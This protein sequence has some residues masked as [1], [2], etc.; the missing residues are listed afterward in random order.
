MSEPSTTPENNNTAVDSPSDSPTAVA[1]P[2]KPPAKVTRVEVVRPPAHAEGSSEDE[3]EGE[4]GE[5]AIEDSQILE[6]LPDETEDI[7][8]IHSRLNSNGIGKLG[9]PR[10]G[11]H[12][13]RLCLRQNFIS[14]LDPEVFGALTA[15]EDLDFY[16]NKIKHVGTALNN[17]A[18]L[19]TLDLS[20]N[21]IKHIPEELE[22]HLAS[23]KTIFF[24]QNRISHIAN[25]GG[26]AATLRS[27]ELGG[28][29]LRKLEGLEGLV[30]LEELWV[31]KNKIT[32]LENLGAVKKLRILSI[33]SNRITK[34]EGLESLENL[35]E[36]YISHNGVQRIEGLENNVK[37]RTIDLGNNFVERL[38]GVSHLTKLEELWINDNKIA[39]LQDIEPQL[40]HI[41]TLETIYLERNPVQ[42]SE[43]AAY[44]RKLI[45]LLP[46]IQQL[47]AT[48]V[49]QFPA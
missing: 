44:R 34:I 29:R 48:Y 43:G 26:L 41:E 37:L 27:V 36:F 31:G 18:D 1:V 49:K 22:T 35:E 39:T 7:E 47:D 45:L 16:D 8:L 40:K 24:V 10:F 15:L 13:K 4:D 2:A 14:H 32:K 6:D 25:L 46:Q 28:N 9:L 30:N 33:Q 19:T 38:E 21:L 20:F 11:A 5:A 3:D 17:M 23:L 42:A 12:L